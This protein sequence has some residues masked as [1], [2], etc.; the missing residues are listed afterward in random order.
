MQGI[1]RAGRLNG[2]GELIV[3]RE[4]DGLVIVTLNRPEKRNAISSALWQGLKTAFDALDDAPDVRSVILT[5]QGSHFSAGADIAEFPIVHATAEA[6]AAYDRA[7]VDALL[8]VANCS[9][10]TVAHISGFAIGGAVALAL[11][12]DFRIG[13]DSA[14]LFIPAG[15]LGVVY[16]RLECELLLRQVGLTN[17][18]HIL[19]SGEPVGAAEALRLGLLTQ[20]VAAGGAQAARDLC[21]RFATS[22]PNSLTGNK[23]ILNAIACGEADTRAAGID[24][25]VRRATMSEDHKEGQRAFLEKRAPVF[26]GR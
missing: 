11:A 8:A 18:K 12:C 5:G 25:F 26:V 17:A 22:A 13:D 1:L 15:R 23:F 3:A 14:N 19:F 10:P 2:V 9:K 24:Q 7:E 20:V 16:N 6:G 4:A 21:H